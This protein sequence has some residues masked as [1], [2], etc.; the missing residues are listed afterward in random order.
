MPGKSLLVIIAAILLGQISFCQVQKTDSVHTSA[1]KSLSTDLSLDYDDVLNDL[2]LFLDSLYA[3][4]S[5]FLVDISA[6]KQSYIY[7]NSTENKI[8]LQ[9]KWT[10]SPL[11]GYY[12]KS[13]VGLSLSG[14]GVNSGSG[15]N[16]YQYA[17]TPSFDLIKNRKWTAG[18]SY[19][20]Y[21]T[22]DS[23]PF[24]T[25]PI[26]NELHAYYLYRKAWL[27][28]GISFNYGWGSRSDLENRIDFITI[29]RE[30]SRGGGNGNGNGNGGGNGNG[31][32]GVNGNGNGNG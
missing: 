27:Q 23:L 9:K 11:V 3:P 7:K 26:Q 8:D 16:L 21:F 30:N 31:N 5:N 2:S 28:P 25:T 32:G 12:H 15:F 19:S 18:I 17:I 1:D 10:I 4:R 20:R 14:N 13:G 24:Y 6:W 29:I 22:K